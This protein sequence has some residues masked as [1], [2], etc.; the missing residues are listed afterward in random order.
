MIFKRR[1]TANFTT[2][3]NGLFQDER[4]KLDELGILTW[5]LSCPE[6]WEVRRPH[7]RKRFKIGRDA[8]RRIVTNLVK[9]G[10]A[11]AC[12]KRLGN[13][14]FYTVY[15][16]R[17][18]CGPERTD[19]EVAAI[20]LL[21]SGEAGPSDDVESD[22]D[23]SEETADHHGGLVAMECGLPAPQGGS[24][25]TA[26][27][28]RPIYKNLINTEDTKSEREHARAK[29]KHALGLAEFK[30]RY[31][32]AASDDQGKIDDEWFKLELDEGEPAIAGIP[33]FLEKLK[34]DKRTTV[35]AAWKYLKEKRWTLL[36]QA[37]AAQGNPNGYGRDSIEAK[38]I[39]TL[40]NIAGSLD[41][42]VK[43]IRKNDVVYYR[44][45]VTPQL[46]AL[47]SAPG[48]DEWIELDRNQAG[49]WNAFLEKYPTI[50]RRAQMRAGSRA[51]RQWPPRVDGAWPSTGPPE[52]YMTAEDE[53]HFN[54]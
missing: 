31:P 22:A 27:P 18:E 15:E 49:A 13:G 7:L 32:T 19:D 21:D 4:L 40:F 52:T 12:R 38:A 9:Y 30:R 11:T 54:G 45:P 46:A 6:N 37:Q 42:F 20:F 44:H 14:T 8:L 51:P 23:V 34:R 2:I 28:P 16:I 35:P 36:E 10:W 3:G 29:E 43:V 48:R 25:A 41:F 50:E 1:H 47:A 39:M 5:L 53:Q 33:P 24:P 17:D 26:D